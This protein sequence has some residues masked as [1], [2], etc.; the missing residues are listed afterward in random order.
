MAT[1]K[2]P[3][4][5]VSVP[6]TD[7]RHLFVGGPTQPDPNWIVYF[8]DFLVEQDYAAADWTIS[9]TEA[10]AG[11]ATEALAAD[12]LAGALL[13]TNAAGDNDLDSLQNTQ[14]VFSMA[15]GREL[16]YE[17]RVKINDVDQVD[18]FYG[19]SITDTTPL[20]ASDK[21]GFRIIDESASIEC[22]TTLNSSTTQT[23]SQ[24]DMAD[25]TYVRLGMRFDGSTNV[26][27]YVNRVLVATHTT[28][29][30]NDEN[31]AITIHHQ[32]GEA[33]AQTTTIDY[34]YLAQERE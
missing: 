29:I 7:A 12:E 19:I 6:T 9:T 21:M 10:G 30:P 1:I 31:L 24:V 20:D 28:N 16:I 15:S 17:T 27:F 8:N 5:N 2:G 13:L 18:N 22:E 34:I 33:V 11:S 23:D 4:E 3:V 14:E 32:N 26:F 25:D